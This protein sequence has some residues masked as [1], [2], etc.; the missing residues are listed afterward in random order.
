[1]SGK[2]PMP[3]AAVEAFA[4][5]SSKA[6]LYDHMKNHLQVCTPIILSNFFQYYMPSY[7]M[8]TKDFAKL[9]FAGDKALLKLREVKFISVTKCDELSVKALY[10]DFISLE[11]MILYFPNKYPKGR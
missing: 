4:L 9:V 3:T 1:M 2:R 10:E 7:E 5:T 11:G 6:D 8:F